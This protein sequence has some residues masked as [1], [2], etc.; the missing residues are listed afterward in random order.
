MYFKQSDFF[1]G[2]AHGFVKD[3]MANAIKTAYET[4]DVIFTETDEARYFYIL[5]KGHVKLH[6]GGDG[7]TAYVIN[8]AG[9]CFGWSS[10]IDRSHY[11][12]SAICVAP[13]ALMRL[14]K[15]NVQN[16]LRNDP[17]TGL[18]FM[19]RLASMI[20]D[21]LLRCYQTLASPASLALNPTEGTGQ[22]REAIELV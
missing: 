1:A 16:V 22:V 5:I 8:R 6:I 13:T 17:H 11:S 21:R 20:G 9:E 7:Y 3:I 18:I 4:D 12:A 2:M 10:L 19:E 15:T 14:E